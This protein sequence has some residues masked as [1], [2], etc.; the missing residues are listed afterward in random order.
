MG[1]LEKRVITLSIVTLLVLVNL[2]DFRSVSNGST[3]QDYRAN[4]ILFKLNLRHADAIDSRQQLQSR[5]INYYDQLRSFNT[6]ELNFLHTT[7]THGW[8]MGHP[9]Q[10]Q[11][12][13]D[14]GDFLSF[15]QRLKDLLFQEGKDLIL[16]DSGDRHD[17]NGLSDCTSPNGLRSN[18]IFSAI[19]FDLLTVGNHELYSE[20]V[21]ELE[22]S[23]VV[24]HYGDRYISTNVEYLTGDGEWVPFGNSEYRVWKSKN[25]RRTILGL[26]FMFDFRYT[27]NERVRVTSISTMIQTGSLDAIIETIKSNHRPEIIV[28]VGHLPVHH[29]WAESR[30]LH[31][32]LRSKF[33]DK[34][35]QYFGGH[36]HI[37][38]FVVHD[39]LSTGLQSGRFCETIGFLSMNNIDSATSKDTS[40]W[41]WDNIDRKYI[42][43]NLH[44]MLFHTNISKVSEFNTEEGV[45]LSDKIIS[46]VSELNL[47]KEYGRVPRNYYLAGR[48]YPHHQS[49]Y[50][51]ISDE[52]LPTM[53][54]KVKLGDEPFE[55]SN[56][57]VVIINTGAIRYDLYKG[58]FSENTKYTISP[59]LNQWR[60][61]PAVPKKIALQ[62]LPTL[63]Q[64][65]YIIS[66]L[67]K[68]A[69]QDFSLD[70]MSD[71][72]N[73]DHSSRDRLFGQ[74][75][76]DL[77]TLMSPFARS[78][79]IEK[80]IMMGKFQ[81]DVRNAKEKEQ[82]PFLPHH[83]QHVL[84]KLLEFFNWNKLTH[85][86]VTNDDFGD[87]GDDTKHKQ[88]SFYEPPCVIQSYQRH[89]NDSISN[90]IFDLVI[91]DDE[92]EVI[93]VVFYD[94]I[95]PYILYALRQI[96]NVDLD[97]RSWV[98][99]R[100]P[101]Y[102]QSATKVGNTTLYQSFLR[103][104]QVYNDVENEWNVGDMLKRYVTE[105]WA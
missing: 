7:D 65:D 83:E 82:Q 93:D 36:S 42:D 52:I 48:P 104:I 14:W 77:T 18:N 102:L 20:A 26:S 61:I 6:G 89:Y 10:P 68:N 15:V 67:D 25:T 49:L 100:E 79:L 92:D 33:S 2:L 57:R 51:L 103:S 70:I 43:F 53:P 85:G 105:N 84:V 30:M 27:G 13:S 62:I 86:Y 58:I 94:F 9:T 5:F 39:D 37:R 8:Y 87:E 95:E 3:S 74:D 88:I 90:I 35:I 24:P 32:Y 38:D 29:V 28:V 11:Y 22:F 56:A 41:A 76:V 1:L 4:N 47:T 45:T 66:N 59:F 12:S 19:D 23:T 71:Y 40:N 73:G 78:N 99:P 72:Y 91:P 54:Y 69:D 31:D 64:L 81:S 97:K 34:I 21:S 16:V 55:P 96:L 75:I 17:G 101:V 80:L 46:T 63:N 98:Q 50:S 44:S 60:V